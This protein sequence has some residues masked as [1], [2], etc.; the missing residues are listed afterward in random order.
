MNK[1]WAI[2]TSTRKL[3]VGAI[4][5]VVAASALLGFL[6]ARAQA[7]GI[8]EDAG[9]LYTGYLETPKGEPIT[10]PVDVVLKLWDAP[11]DGNPVCE[12]NGKAIVPLAGRFQLPLGKEC[13]A[14][15]GA[16]ANLWLEPI[17]N[18]TPLG[19][20]P[21]GAV[22]YAVEAKHAASADAASGDLAKELATLRADIDT[23][24]ARLDAPLT[25]SLSK[26]LSAKQVLTV[27]T[28]TWITGTDAAKLAAG[29]YWVFNTARAYS[30]PTGCTADCQPV[31][32][33]YIAACMK[34]GDEVTTASSQVVI[35]VPR[36]SGVV[37]SL[38]AAAIDYF[39]LPKET[40][41]VQL[42]L[43]AKRIDDATIF[44]T[45]IADVY[46]VVMAQPK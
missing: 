45:A 2:S 13:T 9:M 4:A 44:D 19:R 24:K 40:P 3:R 35:E 27:P 41:D 32:T 43:C 34:V 1:I 16:N 5:G 33:S 29:R 31:A 37:S 22:P 39:D 20:S 18:D 17:V 25:T 7:A 46:S 42:G 14:A 36:A 21:L 15:V 10:A 12:A 8:P 6:A 23:L 28:W 11:A 38:P 26:F 30:T